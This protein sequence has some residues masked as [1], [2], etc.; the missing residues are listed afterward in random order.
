MSKSS[1]TPLAAVLCLAAPLLAGC[2]TNPEFAQLQARVSELEGANQQ[3]NAQ[4]STLQ[5]R[6]G[7][8]A[9]QVATLKRRTQSAEAQV[10]ALSRNAGVASARNLNAEAGGVPD[11]AQTQVI[12][13]TSAQVHALAD[14]VDQ[15]SKDITQYQSEVEESLLEI[16]RSLERIK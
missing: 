16:T 6:A 1:W 15:L 4:V 10:S 12:A 5:K 13:E 7:G 9:A 11:E 2:V 8:T 14:D 3:L